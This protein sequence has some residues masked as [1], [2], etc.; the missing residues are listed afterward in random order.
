MST[1]TPWS[2]AMRRSVLSNSTVSVESSPEEG[3][4]SSSTVGEV[5]RA[6]PSSTRRETPSGQADGQP[7][8][9]RAQA[10]RVDQVVDHRLL[11]GIDRPEASEGE[12]VGP[13]PPLG[14]TGPVGEHQV[15]ADGQAPEDLGMLEGAGQPA[16]G[17]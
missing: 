15:L 17:P 4:S 8:G 5:A 9:H 11:L 10:Q 12:E 6:R 2:L 13:D 7:V 16:L 3:S 1:D 14:R